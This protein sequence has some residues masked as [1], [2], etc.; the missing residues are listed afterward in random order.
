MIEAKQSVFTGGGLTVE[1]LRFDWG[2][3]AEVERAAETAIRAQR[4]RACEAA[5]VALGAR[6]GEVLHRVAGTLAV[7]VDSPSQRAKGL[8]GLRWSGTWAELAT[9]C[10]CN[11]ESIGRAVRRL[12]NAGVV[13]TELLADDRGAVVGVVVEL[14]MRVVQTLATPPGAAPDVGPGAAPD[15][16]PGA[17]PGAK[18][19]YYS[20]VFSDKPKPPPP[21]EA[22]AEFENLDSKQPDPWEEV[23]EALEGA[24]VTRSH[25][26]ILAAKDSRYS[27]ADVLEILG[28]F[29]QHRALF[30][31]PGALVDRIRSGAWCVELPNPQ[32][33]Q[34]R[35]IAVDRMKRQQAFEAIRGQIVLDARRRGQ[36]ISDG[37]ADAMANAALDRQTTTGVQT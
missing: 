36:T 35:A 34:R 13:H 25:A 10:G 6:A 28:Q 18:R 19:P 1:Q 30:D 21:R 11:A 17:A 22:A 24:G 8:T 37:D 29:S 23:R 7:F 33:E 16:G 15:V 2:E 27:P 31:G 5:A 3:S 12:R 20:S 14:Q 26:A 32:I 9:R 4:A